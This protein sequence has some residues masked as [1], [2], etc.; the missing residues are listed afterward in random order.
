M[1]QNPQTYTGKD[2]AIKIDT[3]THSVLGVSDFSLTLDRGTVEQ[4]LVGEEGNYFVAGSLSIDGSFTACKLENSAAGDLLKAMVT[5]SLVAVSGSCGTNSIHFYFKSAAITGFDI[6]LGDA[7]TIT[8]GS[9]DFTVMDPQ[10]V[11]FSTLSE[12]GTVIKDV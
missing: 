1:A 10:N 12:G 7:D 9:I 3:K 6:S 11:T 2:A 4:E 8:E 5:G